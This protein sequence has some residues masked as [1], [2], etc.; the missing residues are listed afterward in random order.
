MR[1]VTTTTVAGL[2]TLGAGFVLGSC[3]S[4]TSDVN[5][6]T[7]GVGGNG[8]G[9]AGMGGTGMNG[10]GNNNNNNNGGGNVSNGGNPGVTPGGAGGMNV[11]TAGDGGAENQAGA[12]NPEAGAGG[13]PQGNG[14]GGN[15]GVVP[16]PVNPAISTDYAACG[17]PAAPAVVATRV[18]TGLSD[19]TFVAFEPE[20]ADRMYV[21]ERGGGLVL[22]DLTNPD[23]ATNKTTIGSLP[24]EGGGERG[25]LSVAF[26]PAFAQNHRFYASFTINEGTDLEYPDGESRGTNGSSVVR[27]YTLENG[28]IGPQVSEVFRV[29]QPEQNHNGGQIQFGLD[30]YLY[31]SLGDGGGQGDPSGFAQY[32]GSTLGKIVRL[33][34]EDVA[35]PVPGNDPSGDPRILHTGFRNPWRFSFDLGK[36]D[37]YI[38]DVGQGSWEEV[39]VAP[40]GS[41]P[42]NFGWKDR[43]GTH[44]HAGPASAAFTDPITE[45]DHGDGVSITGGYVYRGASIPALNGRYIYGDWDSTRVWVVTWPGQGAACDREEL[46]ADLGVFG[47]ISSFGQDPNGEVYIVDLTDGEVSRIDPG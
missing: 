38:G 37:M 13:T 46:T 10:G 29:G 39:D 30:G 43:E 11:G 34:V 3:S 22:V 4:S 6:M 1:A 41:A 7:P 2:I 15:V 20:N 14:G 35:T 40:N 18:A 23:T 33:N 5:Q 25:L 17:G 9:V 19:P 36:G 24:S 8:S 28:V 21:V 32:N 16:L 31:L 12:G 42:L 26:H 45:Y 44:D 47:G 27:E